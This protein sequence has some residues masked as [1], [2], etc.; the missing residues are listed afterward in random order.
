MAVNL[1]NVRWPK[2]G[3]FSFNLVILEFYPP[4]KKATNTVAA[5]CGGTDPIKLYYYLRNQ[6]KPSQP[7]APTAPHRAVPLYVCEILS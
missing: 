5:G 1:T 4:L 7:H 3:L 6:T 2:N